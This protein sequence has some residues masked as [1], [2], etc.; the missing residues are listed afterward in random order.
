[1]PRRSI[2]FRLFVLVDHA[3][4]KRLGDKPESVK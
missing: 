1:M 3:P 4:D 2:L